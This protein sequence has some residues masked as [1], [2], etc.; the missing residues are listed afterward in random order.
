MIMRIVGG[1]V[2]LLVPAHPG[3]PR[4]RAIKRLLVCV[5]CRQSKL[6]QKIKPNKWIKVLFAI[7]KSLIQYLLCHSD[8]PSTSPGCLQPCSRYQW[9][10]KQRYWVDLAAM[11]H[12]RIVQGSMQ[13]TPWQLSQ[14]HVHI[15]SQTVQLTMFL[16]CLFS[17]LYDFIHNNNNNNKHVHQLKTFHICFDTITSNLSQ[18]SHL[19]NSIF[20]ITFHVET[21]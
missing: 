20:V 5:L 4:Q 7:F 15:H 1:W 13:E 9:H 21:M 16:T 10:H 12:S 19:S 17:L 11:P 2:F 14:L 6:V 3:S 8:S 18:M